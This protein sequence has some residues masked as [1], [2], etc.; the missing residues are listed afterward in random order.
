MLLQT[1]VDG[2]RLRRDHV[3]QTAGLIDHDASGFCAGINSLKQFKRSTGLS[4][5][6]QTSLPTERDKDLIATDGDTVT[7]TASGSYSFVAPD[8]DCA[9]MCIPMEAECQAEQVEKGDYILEYAGSS[10]EF[11]GPVSSQSCTAS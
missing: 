9:T 6:S 4:I 10:V 3:E 5:H 1:R 8:E 7:V 11:T 2:S